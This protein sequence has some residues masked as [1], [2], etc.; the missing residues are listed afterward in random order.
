M[1]GWKRGGGGWRV[2]RGVGGGNIR[3]VVGGNKWKSPTLF[4]VVFSLY[5]QLS[6]QL[7]YLSLSLSSLCVAG[8]FCKFREKEGGGCSQIRPYSPI[9]SDSDQRCTRI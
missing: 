2:G 6:Q 1:E 8:F 5:T 7:P 4:A 3:D 9:Y